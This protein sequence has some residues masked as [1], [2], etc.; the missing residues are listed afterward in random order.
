[1]KANN[2]LLLDIIINKKKTIKLYIEELKSSL[3][4]VEEGR[5]LFYQEEIKTKT[6]VYDFLL[7]MYDSVKDSSNCLKLLKNALVSI[8]N[9]DYYEYINNAW[10]YDAIKDL[11][12]EYKKEYK[13]E[14]KY[15]KKI[16]VNGV[17][18]KELFCLL[19]KKKINKYTN[20]NK[21]TREKYKHLVAFLNEFLQEIENSVCP[22]KTIKQ[23]L[24]LY[25]KYKK[26]EYIEIRS[27]KVSKVEVLKEIINEYNAKKVSVRECAISL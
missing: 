9:S 20:C 10:K 27:K 1:M 21:V 19:I 11:I 23:K 12:L 4:D 3:N 25:E 18:D 15:N 16:G 26:M 14:F 17:F 7:G 13:K 8:E 2:E 24:K 5:F 22:L 6:A